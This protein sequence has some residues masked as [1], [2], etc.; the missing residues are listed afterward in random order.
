MA[1]LKKDSKKSFSKTLVNFDVWITAAGFY[2]K[3]C[4]S[5][6]V[7]SSF[8]ISMTSIASIWHLLVKSIGM[9]GIQ[10]RNDRIGRK[11]GSTG[12]RLFP[13]DIIY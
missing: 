5:F 4:Y 8:H 12:L 6:S 1:H 9:L 2:L 7:Y 3:I 11:D 13:Y 10:T